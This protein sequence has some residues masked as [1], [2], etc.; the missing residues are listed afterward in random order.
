M[1]GPF[2][3][4]TQ[5]VLEEQYDVTRWWELAD[6]EAWL[7]DYGG[8]ITAVAT[9]YARG[10]D[11]QLMG[12]LPSLRM[13]ACFGVGVD[14]VD[15]AWCRAHDVAVTNTP[16]VLTDDVADLA[17]ALM[18]ASLRQVVVADRFVRNG[19]WRTGPMALQSAVRGRKVGVVGMGRI[20]RAIA[21][22][23][24]PFG[25]E[26]AYSAPRAKPVPYRH[27]SS[28]VELAAWANVLIA[29]CPGGDET[30][31]LVSREV[32]AALGPSGHFVN[33][34]RGSVVDQEA[35]I[36]ALAAG[37]LAGAALDVFAEEPE[38]P[39]AL[40]A[41]PHVVVQ[42]HHGSATRET[43]QVMGQLVLDNLAAFFAGQALPTP[44]A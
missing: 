18:L 25:V 20:G 6:P 28:A 26:L 15:L 4:P 11:A 39:A 17:V 19:A 29:A 10:A 12:R 14:R 3:A 8:G 22:R 23:L 43:R 36:E 37:R 41:L 38:V 27:V 35:L 21:S 2:H 42:P 16:H 24:A 13:V 32:L 7:R 9:S 33:I 1:L 5:R 31:G 44:V 34:A 30:R 40:L